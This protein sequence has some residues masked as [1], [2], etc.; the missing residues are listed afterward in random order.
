M[1]QGINGTVDY[2]DQVV[3]GATV[4]QFAKD[5]YQIQKETTTANDGGFEFIVDAGE[6]DLTATKGENL[7]YITDVTTKDQF[8]QAISPW[9]RGQ[10]N[11]QINRP[12]WPGSEWRRRCFH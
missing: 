11:R 10:G 1:G 7:G 5:G 6:Y 9:L 3:Q 4:R 8:T 12:K 2:N